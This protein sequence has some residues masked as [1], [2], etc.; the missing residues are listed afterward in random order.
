MVSCRF[1]P[2]LCYLEHPGPCD[3]AAILALVVIMKSKLGRRR[4]M[5]LSAVC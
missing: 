2:A 3:V 5:L 4:F 1:T